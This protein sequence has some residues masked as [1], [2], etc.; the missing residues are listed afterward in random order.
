MERFLTL[1]AEDF[2]R[3]RPLVMV[4]TLTLVADQ[5]NYPA[6]SGLKSIESTD[7]G[8]KERNQYPRWDSRYPGPA[9]LL[10]LRRTGAGVR[11]IWLNPA[12]TAAQIACLTS[13]FTYTYRAGH[14]LSETADDTTI[15]PEDRGLLLLRAQIE[16][17]K[18]LSMRSVGK[19][20]SIRDGLSNVARNSTPAALYREMLDE[21][22]KR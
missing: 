18:E 16:M 14:S 6:P 11:E 13:T 10:R 21:Y 3:R 5:A 20:V 8:S 7:W 15:Q 22:E 12:P 19:P 1:A 17:L 9:P 2:D 4:D